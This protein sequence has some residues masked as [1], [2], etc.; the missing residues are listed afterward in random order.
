MASRRSILLRRWAAVAEPALLAVAL[1]SIPLSIVELL[2]SDLGPPDQRLVDGCGWV[3]WTAFLADLLVRAVL[4]PKPTDLFRRDKSSIAIVLLTA[5]GLPGA[6]AF[7]RLARPVLRLVAVGTEIATEARFV[8]TRHAVAFV[9]YLTVFTW[10]MSAALIL[11][12][13]RHQKF[14]SLADGLWWSAVTMATVGYGD[15]AP[16][17]L[18]GRIVAVAT[19]VVGIGAFSVTTAK[20]FELF[21]RPAPPAPAPS[22]SPLDRS[23]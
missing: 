10:W 19:M 4:L 18:G 20:L 8:L 17:T 11:V 7:L 12:F 15:L 6:M 3:V 23:V 14:D 5:P 21:N 16:V 22:L 9:V 13:E 1:L 2:K